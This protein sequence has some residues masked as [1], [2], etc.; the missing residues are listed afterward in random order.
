MKVKKIT[1]LRELQP[2]E[3]Q[4]K[5]DGMWTELFGLRIKHALGQLENPLQLRTLKRDIARVKTLLCEHGVQERSIRRH[6]AAA[7]R[8]VAPKAAGGKKK[9]EVAA[10]SGQP[11]SAAGAASANE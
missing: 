3:L 5:L 11:A 8:A 9:R 4:H 10:A 6:Q 1:A 7:A 2:E